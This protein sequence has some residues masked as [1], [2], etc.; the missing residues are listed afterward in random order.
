MF[1]TFVID[2]G[3]VESSRLARFTFSHDEGFESVI[4]AMKSIRSVLVE[5]VKDRDRTSKCCL[6]QDEGVKFCPQCGASLRNRKSSDED[7][8]NLCADQFDKMLSMD[9][10]SASNECIW[11]PFEN[12]G[13]NLCAEDPGKMDSSRVFVWNVYRWMED[14]EEYLEWFI[15]DKMY[16]N[17]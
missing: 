16:S 15:H 2:L 14:E 5:I 11:D 12:A 3:Y 10:D 7:Y 8:Y 17:R 4:D 6:K 13:W 9:I 1:T